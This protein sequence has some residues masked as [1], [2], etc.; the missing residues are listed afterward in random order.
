LPNENVGRRAT[1]GNGAAVDVGTEVG[2]AGSA[3]TGGG[4][5]VDRKPLQDASIPAVKNKRINALARMF[6]LS[7]P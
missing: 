2:V 7:L 1:V 3:A 4:V 6:I 5:G